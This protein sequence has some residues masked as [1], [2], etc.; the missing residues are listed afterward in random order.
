MNTTP[1]QPNQPADTAKTD[2]VHARPRRKLDA[3]IIDAIAEG[4]ARGL[5]ESE[6][7]RLLGIDPRVWRNF[8]SRGKNDARWQAALEKFTALRL[9]K[10]IK[11][12]EDCG[13]GKGLRQPD[14]RA[15]AW[16]A[17]V[18]APKRFSDAGQRAA[19]QINMSAPSVWATVLTD[20]KMNEIWAKVEKQFAQEKQQAIAISASAKPKQIESAK[21]EP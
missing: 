2:D 6:C 13:D 9:D 18:I 7:A 5:N 15:K 14:W 1:A 21:P 10:L 4:V 19:V 12:I 11:G 16:L 3:G 20:Q 8:K 17:S